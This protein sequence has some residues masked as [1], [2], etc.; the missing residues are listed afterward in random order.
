MESRAHGEVRADYE[1]GS[2]DRRCPACGQPLFGWIVA[3]ADDPRSSETYVVDR[4]ES[5]GLAVARGSDADAA[6][7]A[8]VSELRA[9][10]LLR[11]PNRASLQAALGGE[12]WAAIELPR[13]PLYLTPRAL[14]LILERQALS[15]A[16]SQPLFSA[17]Q[18]WMWQTLVNA[19]TLRRNFAADARRGRLSPRSLRDRL[20]L[21][22][23]A[24]VTLLIALPVAVV[25]LPLEAFA[26]LARRGGL[27]RVRLERA[28][29]R[30]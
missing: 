2:D 16:I 5:C 15:A 13:Q 22:L 20:A 26:A 19:F 18:R 27:L 28:T 1:R 24:A 7:N 6:A 12:S 21:A 29:A 11:V 30:P 9:G 4:C 3:P 14:A 17:N 8:L 23:D 25:S 10:G